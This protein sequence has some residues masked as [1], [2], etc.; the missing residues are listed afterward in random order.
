MKRIAIIVF[1]C[2]C[3]LSCS[4][5]RPAVEVKTVAGEI[6][7]MID[8][9]RTGDRADVP[10]GVNPEHVI[11]QV[12]TKEGGMITVVKKP[13]HDAE[14]FQNQEAI[15]E[16]MKTVLPARPWYYWP[17]RI[18]IGLAILAGIIF[19]LYLR[20]MLSGIIGFLKRI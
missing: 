12:K 17:V 8:L 6:V 7:Q 15:K 9:Q 10:V 1:I 18:L 16:E 13:F 2:A 5:V 3:I 14:I 19:L 11:A 20:G 4:H